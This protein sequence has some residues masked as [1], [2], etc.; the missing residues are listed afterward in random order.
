V[1]RLTLFPYVPWHFLYFF[2]LPQ[3]QGLSAWCSRGIL[4]EIG[5]TDASHKWVA[6]IEEGNLLEVGIEHVEPSYI[7]LP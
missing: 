5:L 6:D 1:R 7:M 4:K 3:G 2:P